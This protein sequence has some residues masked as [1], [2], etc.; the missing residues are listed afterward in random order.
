M[1]MSM[2]EVLEGI[3]T[4][5]SSISDLAT[6]QIG[7]ETPIV[8]TAYPML[9]VVPSVL[10]SSETSPPWQP[11][12]EILVYYGEYVRPLNEGGL[13]SQY[14]WL[15]TV[16]DKIK[17]AIVPGAGWRA[18]WQETVWDE[19]RIPGMKLFCSRFVAWSV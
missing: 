19:D 17:A 13:E 5:C 14:E 12:M 10:R 3:K 16:E 1:A 7:I 15:L 6:C 11:E 9:R 2:W 8:P 4:A 18:R